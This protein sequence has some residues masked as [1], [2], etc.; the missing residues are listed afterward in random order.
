MLAAG[1]ISDGHEVSLGSSDPCLSQYLGDPCDA[2]LDFCSVTSGH[3][4]TRV[5][6]NDEPRASSLSMCS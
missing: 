2:Q 6:D 1:L 5:G 3:I 4:C